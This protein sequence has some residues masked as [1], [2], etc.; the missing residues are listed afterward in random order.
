MVVEGLDEGVNGESVQ[1]HS[2]SNVD[3]SSRVLVYLESVIKKRLCA[4][5]VI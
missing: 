5:V 4:V 3:C 1:T 2:L